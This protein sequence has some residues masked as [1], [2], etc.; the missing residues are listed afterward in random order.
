[1]MGCNEL[2]IINKNN[3]VKQNCERNEV[4]TKAGGESFVDTC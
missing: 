4:K 3:E 2:N 1:M